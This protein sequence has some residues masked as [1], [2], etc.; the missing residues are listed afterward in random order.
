MREIGVLRALGFLDAEAFARVP[1][2]RRGA[3]RG[4]G[5]A[6]GM[7]AALAYGELIM[8][9]LR[10][11]WVGAVGTRLLSLHRVA[12]GA[13]GRRGG[14]DRCGAGLD[15]LDFARPAPGHAPRPAGGRADSAARRRRRW[16]IGRH[17]RRART[18]FP[19][20]RLAR[21]SIRPR[22]FFGAG[23]LL[24]IAA[25]C[26]RIRLAQLRAP[27]RISAARSRSAC[28]AP[29]IGPDAASSVSR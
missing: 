22:G 17:R 14:G 11:W 20:R 10:T 27:S 1:A 8:F 5:H 29:A 3:R 4:R 19:R 15:R 7:G 2:R 12:A 13:G 25:L 16:I 18:G 28:A 23:T 26:F 6:S 9:G 24:L 21:A